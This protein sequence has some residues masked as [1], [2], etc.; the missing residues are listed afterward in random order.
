M[1]GKEG[2][3]GGGQA[4]VGDGES[5]PGL[6]RL[7]IWTDAAVMGGR[8]RAR[9]SGQA[10]AGDGESRPGLKR[11]QIWTDATVMG[12]KE[13]AQGSG[14]ATTIA[15]LNLLPTHHLLK[16]FSYILLKVVNR[17]L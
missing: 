1:G 17:I 10:A 3:R 7:P 16:A 15:L 5:R 12:G 13:R 6:Q 2:A 9:G 11:L 4:A 8:E 14:Q